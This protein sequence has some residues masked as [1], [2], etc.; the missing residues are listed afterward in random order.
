MRTYRVTK[1]HTDFVYSFLGLRLYFN[2]L[3]TVE[4]DCELDSCSTRRTRPRINPGNI[5]ISL[6]CIDMLTNLP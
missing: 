4:Y 1:C 3:H 5:T 2:L 6:Q